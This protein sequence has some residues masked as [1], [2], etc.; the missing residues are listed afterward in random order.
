MADLHAPS[1]PATRLSGFYENAL[2]SLELSDPILLRLLAE[3]LNRQRETLA[4]VASC[5]PVT[6]AAL[7]AEGS[8]FANVTA[9]GY[10]GR[11]YHAGCVNVDRVEQL[12][13]D[14]ARH[15]FGARHANVQP[16]SAS[17]ANQ[18]VMTSLLR[19]GDPLLGLDLDAG[20]H[21]SHG[22]P[23]NV[24][25]RIFTAHSYGLGPNGLIDYDQVR[26][27]AR[28]HRPR[29][30]IAG[31]T[32]YPR[33]IDW[34]AFREI[35]DEVGAYLL[36][37]ISHVAGLVIAGLYPSPIDHAHVVTT[38]THKQLYGPRG[39]LILLGDS[40][41]MK[42]PSGRTLKQTIDSGTFP[43]MQGAP[44]VN[45]I[46]AKAYALGAAGGPAFI[47]KM[48]RIRSLSAALAKE[49]IGQGARIM[50]GG[51]DNHIVVADVLSSFDLTGVNAEKALEEC[52]I[53]V[54]KNRI[55][56]DVHPARVTSGVRFGSN[57][58]AAREFDPDDVAQVAG[59][60][61]RVLSATK[62]TSSTT[63]EL[64]PALRAYAQ[65]WIQTVCHRRPI[66]GY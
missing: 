5:S 3:E 37:D 35:A 42:L 56:D 8:V 7:L 13:I 17:T 39:G 48:R 11:R 12:A 33:T 23:V 32:A 61:V 51:T 40:A 34:A 31:T 18:I 65:Q 58:M 64:P 59:L 55:V 41:T 22:A 44:V 52:G 4:L 45:N 66:A 24:S 36:A 10:P 20:G 53:L 63:Y 54:N 19:P 60:V 1:Q 50:S 28:G 43:L 9:E 62:N 38:C 29:L 26:A 14:R 27:K 30:V 47:E 15:V 2:D 6:P 21:L 49:L 16:H 57:G 46:A 25:G